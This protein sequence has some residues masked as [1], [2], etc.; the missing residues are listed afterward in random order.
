MIKLKQFGSKRRWLN[1]K[2]SDDTGMVSW[3]VSADHYSLDATFDV[4]DCSRKISLDFGVYGD[5][6]TKDATYRAKKLDILIG[7]LQ[8][9]KDAMASAYEYRFKMEQDKDDE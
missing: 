7:E 5:D 6:I 1:P 2:S 4:W 3:S 9:M 8:A